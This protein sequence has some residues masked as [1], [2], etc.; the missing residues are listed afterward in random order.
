MAALGDF[1]LAS[2]YTAITNWPSSF[3]IK[4]IFCKPTTANVAKISKLFVASYK[5]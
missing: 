2:S 5:N 1:K 4:N 3:G